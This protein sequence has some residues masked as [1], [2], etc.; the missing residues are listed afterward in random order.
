MTLPASRSMRMRMPAGDGDDACSC[1]LAFG[2]A[3]SNESKSGYKMKVQVRSAEKTQH[4]L[5]SNPS[6]Y[7]AR[8]TP[9]KFCACTAVSLLGFL[10][11]KRG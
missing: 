11:Y 5:T 3:Q 4:S 8:K 1:H 6:F 7:R 10:Q 9:P 2:A